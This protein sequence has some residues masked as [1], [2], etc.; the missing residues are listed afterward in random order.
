MPTRGAEAAISCRRNTQEQ[1][2]S[3]WSTGGSSTAS[4]HGG[5]ILAEYDE[6]VRLATLA[7]A[8]K[9]RRAAVV[10]GLR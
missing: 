7:L 9:D 10:P 5:L 1:T 6:P 8:D 4:R 2:P 3:K